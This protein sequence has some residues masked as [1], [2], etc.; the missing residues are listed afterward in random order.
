MFRKFTLSHVQTELFDEHSFFKAFSNDMKCAKH[1]VI[2]ESPYITARRAKEFSKLVSKIR[3]N[4]NITIHTRIPSHHDSNLTKQALL[5]IEIL[6][7]IG[8]SIIVC[9]DL[10]HRKFA[11]ID[12]EILWEGSLNMLSH[13][14]SREIMRRTRSTDLCSQM[15]DFTR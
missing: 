4:L 12:D 8:I 5:G 15:I 14:N 13:S 9:S 3:N 6:E 11:I 1:S 2:I 7:R 10:R